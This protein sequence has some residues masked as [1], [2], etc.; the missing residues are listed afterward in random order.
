LSG[1][2]ASTDLPDVLYDLS[3]SKTFATGAKTTQKAFVIN[4]PAYASVGATTITHAFTQYISGGPTAVG[5]GNVTI[6]NS[7]ALGV[8][9]QTRFLSN[10]QV[11]T[12]QIIAFN[13]LSTGPAIFESASIYELSAGPNTGQTMRLRGRS[14]NT[15][16]D[17]VFA[18]PLARGSGD[19]VIQV[20]ISTSTQVFR[21]EGPYTTDNGSN[22]VFTWRKAGANSTERILVGANDTA[23][24]GFKALC[25]PN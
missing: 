20:M 6:T 3:S 4:P 15:A 14:S 18:S 11:D 10:V 9:G 5:G 19:A 12:N 22:V 13:S 21:V 25:V 7:W 16:G 17:I 1:L 23:G 24:A 8:G 2:S